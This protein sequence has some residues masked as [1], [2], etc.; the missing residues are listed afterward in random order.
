MIPNCKKKQ[1]INTSDYIAYCYKNYSQYNFY[2][3]VSVSF[4]HKTPAWW[5][6]I[7]NIYYFFLFWD[8]CEM[9]LICKWFDRD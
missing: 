6:K 3:S 5:V 2:Y 1:E 9:F 8:S 7:T 4:Y